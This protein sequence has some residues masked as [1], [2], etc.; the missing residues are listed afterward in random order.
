MAAMI[1]GTIA[2]ADPSRRAW[3]DPSV[4]SFGICAVPTLSLMTL[5]PMLNGC[6]TTGCSV[7]ARSSF[8]LCHRGHWIFGALQNI[9]IYTKIDDATLLK[10]YQH[11]NILFLPLIQS[12]ANNAF[13][14]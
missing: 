11:C 13:L 12:T 8:T 6:S 10:F 3:W 4:Y 14:E 9:H 5:H 1:F 2:R 7:T